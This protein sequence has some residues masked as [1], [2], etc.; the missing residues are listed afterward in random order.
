MYTSTPSYV[1]LDRVRPTYPCHVWAKV[2]VVL[3]AETGGVL[4]L[5]APHTLPAASIAG[6]A[7]LPSCLCLPLMSPQTPD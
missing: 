3:S 4:L 6:E 2:E 7:E 1:T 5:P